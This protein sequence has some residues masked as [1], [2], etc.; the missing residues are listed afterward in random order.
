MFGE[1][2][3]DQEVSPDRADPEAACECAISSWLTLLLKCSV[4]EIV[5]PFYTFLKVREFSSI[6][7]KEDCVSGLWGACILN[8]AL[9][10]IRSHSALSTL[11][12]GLQGTS[13]IVFE[14][15]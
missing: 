5:T 7:F 14:L 2:D 10:D 4:S 8:R 1:E 13:G 6:F 11:A 3:A 12:E 9:S 15:F